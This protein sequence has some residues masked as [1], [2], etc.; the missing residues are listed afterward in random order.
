MSDDFN[1]WG[2]RAWDALRDD[3]NDARIRLHAAEQAINRLAGR[4]ADAPPPAESP[5]RAGGVGVGTWLAIITGVLVPIAVAV[6][7]MTGGLT[8]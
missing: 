1:G 2:P 5:I 6:L 7:A 4:P 3:I 8:P